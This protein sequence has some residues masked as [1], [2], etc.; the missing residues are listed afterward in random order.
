MN[1]TVNIVEQEMSSF[2]DQRLDESVSDMMEFLNIDV[3]VSFCASN[4]EE[5]LCSV[6]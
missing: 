3:D 2:E 6:S 4:R 5:A 1:K